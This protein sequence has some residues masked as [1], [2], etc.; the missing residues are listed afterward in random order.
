MT[1]V[2]GSVRRVALVIGN[3][4]YRHGAPLA[5]PH[6]DAETIAG[7]LVR[8]GFELTRSPANS[9]PGW[10]SDL[11]LIPMK[12][13]IAGFGIAAEQADM[14]VIYFAGHGME[15]DG[16]NY[17]LPVDAELEH[18]RR[19]PAE[20]ASLQE[21]AH[22]V[23][24]AKTLPLI[25]LD[26]CRNNPFLERMRGLEA[27]RSFRSGLG[28]IKFAGNLFVAY[29]THQG[30]KAQDGPVGGNSPFAKAL[31][32]HLETP[33]IDIRVL[34]GR[35][36]D[37]V[38]DATGHAQFPHI[39][40]SLGGGEICL[41]LSGEAKPLRLEPQQA[42]AIESRTVERQPSKLRG[43]SRVRWPWLALGA[44][45]VALLV[46]ALTVWVWVAYAPAIPSA[47]KPG[48]SF[49]ECENCPWMVAV[50]PG[51]FVM[52]SPSTEEGHNSDEA[53]LH[54]VRIA[55][56]FAVG[57]SHV[58]R[59]E[60]AAFVKATGYATGDGCRTWNAGALKLEPGFS[61]RS[62]GFEQ[63]DQHPVVCVSWGD[64]DAYVKWLSITNGATYRLLSEAEAEYAARGTSSP[65]PQLRYFFG[66]DAADMCAYANGADLSFKR[67]YPGWTTAPCDDG[68]VFTAPVARFK[69]NAF[70]LYDVHG[71]VWSWT[72]DCWSDDYRDAAGDGLPRVGGSCTHRVLRGG[73]WGNIPQDLRTA[74]R[75]RF[76][77][78]VRV[79]INSF[80]VA[81]AL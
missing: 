22:D 68:N 16:Q 74:I 31:A 53:P 23:A 43:H 41:K 80:R 25:I 39:Y 81:R 11:D 62:P 75:I 63:D 1:T 48:D 10:H 56:A 5:N 60:F 2:D 69:P 9:G 50:P 33:D 64:A 51:S 35:V 37:A 19:V 6:K 29:A 76:P 24:G 46:G 73:A 15:I 4:Q 20:T 57:R 14:A 65:G 7:V 77:P 45:A 38:R 3:A 34:M 61:W 21:I 58:T 70:G 42:A 47:L 79:N 67:V 71:N 52:G 28:D 40:G 44:S 54:E 78:E 26:A 27:G 55:R 49:K 8:L 32:E 66:N 12:K 30:A 72:Q 36:R 59:G 13:L 18:V 17:L